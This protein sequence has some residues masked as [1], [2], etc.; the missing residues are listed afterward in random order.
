MEKITRQKKK[1][2]DNEKQL[3]VE[4]KRGTGT[5]YHAWANIFLH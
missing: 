2:T 5:L 3:K 1:K 4:S